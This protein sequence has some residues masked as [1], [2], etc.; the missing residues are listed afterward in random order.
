MRFQEKKE[1]KM[2]SA[3]SK[4]IYRTS[5]LNLFHCFK[6][7]ASMLRGERERKSNNNTKTSEKSVL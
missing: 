3:T 4:G 7:N 1:Q 2:M 6:V 5:W